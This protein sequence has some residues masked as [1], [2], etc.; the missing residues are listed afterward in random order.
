VTAKYGETKSEENENTSFDIRHS[1]LE[2]LLQYYDETQ[3]VMLDITYR[4]NQDICE[5]P[6]QMWYSGK[7]QSG[8]G[9]AYSKLVFPENSNLQ[10]KN[11]ID[12]II[13]PD[14]S[15]VLVLVDHQGCQQESVQE[16]EL[17]THLASRLL[18]DYQLQPE[19]LALISPHR[20]QNNR[21][22]KQ[23]EKVLPEK[24]ELPLI[25]TVERI[26]GAERDVVLFSFT[27]SD[28]DQ[29]LNQFL[30]NPNRFNVAITRARKKLIVIGSK[31][32]F[33]GIADNE[34]GLKA[35]YCF[36]QFFQYCQEKNSIFE[37]DKKE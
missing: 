24:T 32:F 35:S 18:N 11:L 10:S 2:H 1:I 8:T 37:W 36:K 12:Q 30:N 17:V 16:A 23:L 28:P 20:A 22:R 27:S 3:K 33:Y 31:A 15:V 19:Q 14:L 6:S 7:L 9:N 26:Q 5:F 29:I 34:S 13:N 25:D 4:M 21:I